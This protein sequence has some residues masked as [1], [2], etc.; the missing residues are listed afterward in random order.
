MAKLVRFIKNVS[1]IACMIVLGVSYLDIKDL[2]VL[3]KLYLDAQNRA[4]LQTDAQTYFFS[5]VVLLVL[6]NVPISMIAR[7]LRGVPI[8]KFNI[9]NKA[10]WTESEDRKLKVQSIFLL[11]VY[12]LAL[13]INMVLFF[14]VLKIWAINRGIGGQL[15]DYAIILVTFLIALIIWIA[16]IALRLRIPK[17][18]LV[19]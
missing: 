12:S 19:S 9:P 6:L 15:G 7:F 3:V 11:W 10:F 4:L 5:V 18:E 16:Y 17:E 14:T 1:I 13:I 8:S 2:G